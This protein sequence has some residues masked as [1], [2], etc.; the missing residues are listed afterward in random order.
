MR[1]VIND[2]VVS[3]VMATDKVMTMIN[4]EGGVDGVGKK[5]LFIGVED[6]GDD[7]QRYR[8]LRYY[9]ELTATLSP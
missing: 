8:W 4:N 7:N 3:M 5:K 9:S 2:E 6:N 1:T